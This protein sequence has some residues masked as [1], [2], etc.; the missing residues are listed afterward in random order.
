MKKNK[1][2]LFLEQSKFT[3]EI[4]NQAKLNFVH[5]DVKQKRWIFDV[6]LDD[7]VE[8]ESM[9]LF[10]QTMKSYFYI[11][12]IVL[13]VDLSIHYHSLA[14]LGVHALRYFEH[15]IIELSKQKARFSVLKNFK[16]RFENHKFIIEIDSDSTYVEAYTDEIRQ[17]INQYGID[18]QIDLEVTSQ[19]P[20]ISELIES[21]I[22][23]QA[24]V[25]AQK[26]IIAKKA[27]RETKKSFTRKSSP[28]AIAI[29][30]IPLDQYRLDKYKNE[31][32]DT[33]F[34]IEGVIFKL[35]VKAL[36][37]S[38]LL[39]FLLADKDDAIYVKRFIKSTKDRDLAESL[40][41][42]DRI[43]VEGNATYDTFQKDVVVFANAINFI[44][45]NKKEERIDKAK[46]K[47]IE[48]HLH[49]KMSNMD[50]VMI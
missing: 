32:G 24:K 8:P 39:T 5:V 20:K 28:Q 12:K 29:K 15:A 19:L 38:T 6:E 47:R 49:T 40:H 25:M 14:S 44:E 22:E 35:E 27:V 7:I 16:V 37:N 36:T 45:Q 17:A 33:N 10:M 3:S 48:F 41:E 4:L 13:G 26:Q 31:K 9:A 43:Q 23:E 30:E 1:F 50:A 42:G 2:T 21:S 46:E 11:P 34:L 18:I